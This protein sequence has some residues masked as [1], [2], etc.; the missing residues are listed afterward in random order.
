MKCIPGLTTWAI[1]LKCH[2][3]GEITG[4]RKPMV[5]MAC[6]CGNEWRTLSSLCEFCHQPSETP[7]FVDCKFCGDKKRKGADKKCDTRQQTIL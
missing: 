5:N 3:P 2:K 7:Y 4:Y 6:S 1:C